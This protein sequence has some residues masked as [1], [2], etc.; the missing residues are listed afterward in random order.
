MYDTFADAG[1]MKPEEKNDTG[2]EA[3][4]NGGEGA[5]KEKP[6]MA[7]AKAATNQ[8]KE[9]KAK[10]K[11]PDANGMYDTF[12]DAGGMKPEEM[13]DKGREATGKG[14]GEGSEKENSK[15]AAT[16]AATNQ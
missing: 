1:G 15:M 11:G 13:N 9:D 10:I 16:K 4:G 14:G 2:R 8:Q 6:K 5:E 12:A 7:A 3:T